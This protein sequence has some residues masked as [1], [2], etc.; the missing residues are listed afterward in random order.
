MNNTI[1]NKL[2]NYQ[3]TPPANVWDNIAAALDK[4]GASA[5]TNKLYHFEQEPPP[6]AW[7][8]ISTE[9]DKSSTPAFFLSP[10]LKSIIR[11][12]AVFLVLLLIGIVVY[13]NC[14][15]SATIAAPLHQQPLNTKKQH[16]A[17]QKQMIHNASLA[18]D[19]KASVI[20]PSNV[21]TKK[22]FHTLNSAGSL[23]NPSNG[24]TAPLPKE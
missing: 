9:L 23:P 6:N 15:K 7:E 13:V 10:G 12:A 14:N 17:I 8:K 20:H 11:Y 18:N 22:T 2:F 3:A 19:I 16:P 21:I 24:N 1:K 5:Y 4:E